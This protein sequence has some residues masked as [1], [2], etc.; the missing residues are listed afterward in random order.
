MFDKDKQFAPDGRLDEMFPPGP[1]D[2]REGAEL[3]LWAVEPKGT[4]PT[5]VGEAR[6]TWLT[7]SAIPTPD[8]KKTVG[9]L[10]KPIAE[11]GDDQDS[12]DFPCIVRVLKVSTDFNDALVLN[13]MG[14]YDPKSGKVTV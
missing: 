5:E 14:Q 6:M 11:K 8:E 1:T 4:F 13:W 7:V 12:K 3:I 9:T 10:S 2:S